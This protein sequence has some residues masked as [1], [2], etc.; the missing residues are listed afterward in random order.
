M[1]NL[2]SINRFQT[3]V[4]TAIN[5]APKR[6]LFPGILAGNKAIIAAPQIGIQIKA[7]MLLVVSYYWA[8]GIGH[9]ALGMINSLL[10]TNY[11]PYYF[12]KYHL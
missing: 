10:I 1:S 8:L 3:K 9:W 5:P 11:I 2:K 4:I 12:L 7:L 6:I